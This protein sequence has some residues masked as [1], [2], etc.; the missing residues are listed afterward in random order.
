MSEPC[1]HPVLQFR[2]TGMFVTGACV[3]CGTYRCNEDSDWDE[4][5]A[6]PRRAQTREEFDAQEG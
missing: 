5:T 1:S 2:R 6:S 4:F 3:E